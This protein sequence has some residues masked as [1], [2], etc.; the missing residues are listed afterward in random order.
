MWFDLLQG[1]VKVWDIS[2]P[3]N[4]SPISQLDCLVCS[5]LSI[6]AVIKGMINNNINC[7]VYFFPVYYCLHY[8]LPAAL[9]LW[10][11]QVLASWLKVY[12]ILI[13][14]FFKLT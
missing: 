12:I 8:D 10:K 6:L 7:R 11:S 14:I 13:F 2:Q 9:L 5:S 1:C 3:G 4:K